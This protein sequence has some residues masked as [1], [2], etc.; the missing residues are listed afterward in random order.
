M[1][2]YLR[3]PTPSDIEHLRECLSLD[4]WHV[5]QTE[6]QW[7]NCAGGLTTFYDHKGPIFHMAF[8]NEPEHTLRVHC[9]FDLREKRRTA[10]GL[11]R[12][13]QQITALAAKN[14][15][16]QIKFNSDSPTLVAFF[17]RLG[18][19]KEGN[20]Y[21]L[22]LR[23]EGNNDANVWAV[24]AAEAVGERRTGILQPTAI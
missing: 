16:D 1:Q 3:A 2:V 15:Y 7:I 14:L 5:G 22:T 17:D 9:Q 13:F 21:T 10:V 18:F 23:G 12:A 8:E 24:S 4:I 19:K 11:V 20:E 6:E